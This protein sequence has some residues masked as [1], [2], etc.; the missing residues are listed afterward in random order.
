M[1]DEQKPPEAMIQWEPQTASE[2]VALAKWFAQSTLMPREIKTAPDIFVTIAA[3]RD[4]GWSP[5][6]SLRGIYVVKGKPS[7]SA[8]AMVALAKARPDVCE[9]F[10]R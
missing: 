4:F 10:L 8:D 6:Q 1:S 7:L 5:M 9:Y 3:G 2:G